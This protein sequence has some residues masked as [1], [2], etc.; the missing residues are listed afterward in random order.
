MSITQ[1]RDCLSQPESYETPPG[2][3]WPVAGAA[4]KEVLRRTEGAF[5]LGNVGCEWLIPAGLLIAF[6]IGLFQF[7]KVQWVYQVIYF[8]ATLGWSFLM[9]SYLHDAQ[10]INGLLDGEKLIAQTM[11]CFGTE[12]A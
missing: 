2:Y 1:R 4:L 6:A 7:L 10:H 11:V 9:F 8:A 5:S 3:V 12:A